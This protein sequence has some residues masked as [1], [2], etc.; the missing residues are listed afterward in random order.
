MLSNATRELVEDEVG[1]VSVR[2]L[3]SYRLKDIDRPEK[4]FQVDIDGL[5]TEFPLLSAETAAEPHPLRRRALLAAA[6]AGVLAAAVV[7]V[8]ALAG[9]GPSTP[10]VL[11]NSVKPIAPHTLKVPR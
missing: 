11:P 10:T 3:G 4:L 9:H 1:G 6:L 2:D 5:P 8:F 7:G